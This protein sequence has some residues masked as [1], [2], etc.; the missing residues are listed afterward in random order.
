M[1]FLINRHRND[2]KHPV[3]ILKNRFIFK[4]MNKG[5]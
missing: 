3:I 1:F 4:K 2:A 5:S